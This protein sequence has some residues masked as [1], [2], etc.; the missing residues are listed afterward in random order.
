MV[1]KKARKRDEGC[2]SGMSLN[3]RLNFIFSFISSIA[4][5]LV[6]GQF[7]SI[8]V[9]DLPNSGD[10]EVGIVSMVNG[11]SMMVTALPVGIYTD[12]LGRAVV[13]RCA[14]I[15][16]LVSSA[17]MFL[18]VLHDSLMFMYIASAVAG[19]FSAMTNSPL[20][21]I[22]ADSLQSG[23]R[24]RITVL[25]YA[26]GLIGSAFGPGIAC[27]FFW[28][29]GDEW[30]LTTLRSVMYAGIVVNVISCLFLWLFDD[31]ESLGMESESLL[32]QSGVAKVKIGMQPSKR[33][34]STSTSGSQAAMEGFDDEDMHYQ[35]MP[36]EDADER[37]HTQS[38]SQSQTQTPS[39]NEY[40]TDDDND[41]M[42]TQRALNKKNLGHQRL[43]LGCC[44][45][46]VRSI[47]YI[48][49]AS[50]LTIS[51]GAGMTVQFFSLFFK[52]DFSM[53]PFQ[54][55]G[56]FAAAPVLIAVFF[57]FR[58]SDKS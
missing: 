24:T 34:V 8:F 28:Q 9:A 39:I 26:L 14:C 10:V 30:H 54:I 31:N 49:F 41:D 42:E 27:I 29:L 55:A 38:E 17:L 18:S 23:N 21:S 57:I 43:N 19:V 5:S 11:L 4:N 52:D 13:L 36:K 35:Q 56:T 3:V 6:Y 48:I 51:T 45:L 58:I 20:C 22:L 7:W 37:T 32:V 25:N 47:P 12:K 50:D 46:T 1:F 2:W 16:G 33:I 40:P 53:T 15:V 44:T